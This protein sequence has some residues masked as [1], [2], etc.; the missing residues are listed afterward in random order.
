MFF[1]S[2]AWIWS[3]LA[4]LTLSI[5]L[6]ALAQ[7]YP[8]KPLRLVVPFPPGGSGDAVARLLGQG[9]SERLGQAVI[10]DNRPGANLFIGAQEVARAPA[11]GYTLLMGLDL[12]FTINP[13]TFSRLPYD[14]V[15]DFMPVSQV[16]SQ[17]MWY[18]AGPKL[19]VS[20]MAELI[21]LA[22]SQP[23]KINYGSGALIGQLTGEFLKS[24]TGAEMTYIP[25][26]GSAGA[27]QALLA[28]DV[29]LVV[30][31]IAPFMQY[32]K[33]ER[34]KLL[35][36]T[37]RARSSTLSQVP[38]MVEMGIKD[39][40]VSNWFA[41]F[42]PAGTPAAIVDRLNVEIGRV[43]AQPE[44]KN[45][46][47]SYGLEAQASTPAALAKLMSEDSI[48]W[49]RIIKTAGIKLD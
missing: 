20:S 14:P 17:T 21:A 43:L 19:R 35:G 26:K 44:T 16:T 29:D 46:L 28:G 9:L 8:A 39:F 1:L 12:I 30:S 49:E 24:L 34:V 47:S 41:V 36:Q 40:E 27:A 45:R 22:K 31:D 11:D 37:G 33:T 6:P 42:A 4:F 10:I 5:S 23:G 15:K 2:R 38:T 7:T 3:L 48:K 18:V 32:A 25:Y 13:H